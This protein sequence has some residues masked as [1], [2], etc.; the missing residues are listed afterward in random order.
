MTTPAERRYRRLL[1][2]C[3]PAGL[4]REAE[5]DL[6]ETFRQSHA[7]VASRHAIVRL[8]FWLRM[9]A[10][11]VVTRVAEQRA[12]RWAS[13]HVAP[14]SPPT[15][16]KDIM[17]LL[18]QIRSA[19]RLLVKNRGFAGTAV[20]TLTLGIGAAVAIFSVVN[21]VLL[22][23]LPYRDPARL[24]LVWQEL[25]ARSVPEFPFPIGDIP[26]LREKGTLLESVATIQTG[27]QTI[28]NAEG[29]PEQV[30]TAF[31][32]ANLF[33]LLG[34]GV[35]QGRG[36][37][38]ADGTPLPPPPGAN[39]AAAPAPGAAPAAPPPPPVF[40]AILSH[41]FWV[42]RYGSDP[43][44]VGQL[45]PFGGGARAHVV[46]VAE[47]G[48][49]LLFAPRHNVERTPDL[50]FAARLDFA[51]GSR[52][53]GA[54]RVIARLKPGVAVGQAQA[55]MEALATELRETYPVKKNAGVYINVVPMHATLVSDVRVAILALMGA[56][57]FV[58]LIACANVANLMMTQSMRRERELA[59]R[60]ALGARRATLIR[61]ILIESLVLAGVG[62]AA[63]LGLARLGIVLLQQMGPANLPRL[64][65]VAIDFRVLGFAAAA[66][67]TSALL[68]GLLPA[69][70][71]SRLNLV[72]SLRQGGRSAGLSSGR[73]RG[74]LVV[75]EVALT[76]VLL[77]GAGLMLRSLVILER[78]NPGYDPTGILTFTLGNMATP[79]LEARVDLTRRLRETIGALPGVEGVSAASPL[80]L[81]GGT[82]NMPWGTEEAA[83]DPTRFQQA[84][85]HTTLPGYFDTMRT[86]IRE[87]R[88]FT[89]ADRAPNTQRVVIDERLAAR[90]YPGESAVG[91]T[92]LLRVGGVSP[93]PW[94]IIGVVAHQRHASLAE[95]GREA[96]FFVDGVGGFAS[97]WIVRTSGDPL[98]LAESVRA[99]ITGVVGQAVVA[100]V[101][102]MSAFVD[103]AQAP[104]RF[105]LALTGIFAV[106]AAVLAVVGLYGVLSTLVRQRT[107]EIGVRL[108]F[109]A[110]R[111]SIFRLIVIRGLLLAGVGVAIGVAAA[112]GLTRGIQSM[113]VGVQ[114]ADPLTFAA[115]TVLFLGVAA[116]ACGIPAFRA[117]RLDPTVALRAE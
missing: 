36:F 41:E 87:G 57:T 15:S 65:N 89:E 79:S 115:I 94:E 5:S 26:D 20:L 23:P 90:A 110:E 46:G 37:E 104:T 80:P 7:R 52:T 73:L 39:A 113:L 76:F 29:Q 77:I 95:D 44:I 25:R 114:A 67:L 1:T 108:A 19:V 3:L 96:L 22:E 103:R 91:R 4:R 64:Q 102:P 59:V 38:E 99:A 40:T 18:H 107:A 116:A 55:Q 85:V 27:R 93:T 45:I 101:Q 42:R 69:L 82:A 10:D 72:D 43:A 68:F 12:A 47:P 66:A 88:V 112:L 75:A 100:E 11:L 111:G 35:V 33:D 106:I 6:V 97:R 17:E 62:A 54:V 109:G 58:L 30:R 13:R 9:A 60:T 49:Q 70:R 32:T 53:A 21:A 34:L 71:A 92:L 83:S 63:G 51:N 48:A 84:A 14:A 86:P 98:R 78:V 16:S 24:V 8:G 117:S 28:P 31:V 81:D 56:V 50:W 74:G 2:L 105:A 61:Q